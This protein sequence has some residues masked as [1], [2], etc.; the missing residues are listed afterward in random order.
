MEASTKRKILG[1]ILLVTGLIVGLKFSGTTSGFHA[2]DLDALLYGVAYIG[3]FSVAFVG[4][5]LIFYKEKQDRG[6]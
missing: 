3:G 1:L 4:A 2:T 5:V 6:T